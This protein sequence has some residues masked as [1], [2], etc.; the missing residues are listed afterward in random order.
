MHRF[1][2]IPELVKHLIELLDLKDQ[3]T[4]ARAC[5]LLWLHAVSC[6]WGDVEN[7]IAFVKLLPQDAVHV[8]GSAARTKSFTLER[9]L[10]DADWERFLL[11]SQHTKSL[12]VLFADK[13]QQGYQQLVDNL[14][15]QP[16]FPKLTNI[17]LSLSSGSIAMP[18]PA[19][20]SFF[21]PQSTSN[22]KIFADYQCET[23]AKAVLGTVS[24]P[25]LDYFAFRTGLARDN[26]QI[27]Y[28][29]M[30]SNAILAHTT[31]KALEVE[32][33]WGGR[34]SDVIKAAG[35]LPH[36]I[37]ISLISQFSRNTIDNIDP[38]LQSSQDNSFAKVRK[39]KVTGS[40]QLMDLL[41]R[42]PG[43]SNMD[44]VVLDFDIDPTEDQLKECLHSISHFTRLKVLELTVRG[45]ISWNSIGTGL[46]ACR[47]LK[48]FTAI[49]AEAS[50]L[51]LTEEAFERM[52]TSRA[53]P[54][55]LSHDCVEV[56]LPSPPSS[57]RG[58][59]QREE[60]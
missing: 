36:L 33:N 54:P 27:E 37:D 13:V 22:L 57:L 29:P 32:L 55:P 42:R 20:Y 26:P 40:K 14:P 28:G 52:A 44:Q 8:D 16:V 6:M 49:A 43:P 2:D 7:F 46:N 56:L 10:Q 41:L 58:R 50:S 45:P 19:V 23:A 18:S 15:S 53:S 17:R 25:K 48:T 1:W 34:F 24:L 4:V 59:N 47:D 35:L 31:I 39:V 11:H 21:I 38:Q 30:I 5:R 12:G 51:D 60:F 3:A 9:P